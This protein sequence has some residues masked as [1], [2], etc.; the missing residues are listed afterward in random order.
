MADRKINLLPWRE[1]RREEQKQDFLKVLG[2]VVLFAGIIV[3]AGDRYYNGEIDLQVERNKY[4]E[5][6]IKVLEQRIA[7][8]N[9][10]KQKRNQLLAR[11]T[12]IQ[13][14]QGNRPVIVRLFDELA[15]QLSDKV[16]FTSLSYKGKALAING[17]AETNNRISNQLRN[18]DESRWFEKPNVT[19]INANRSFG[20]QASNFVLQVQQS[21]PKSSEVN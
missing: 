6:E 11:M 1:E 2:V 14:L 13:E 21:T 19:G 17:V 20:P 8:I 15:R 12:V 3:F 5:K 7:E 9:Q 18:F 4:L 10:L 16:Y